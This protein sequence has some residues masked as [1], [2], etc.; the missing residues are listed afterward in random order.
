VANYFGHGIVK[1]T[2]DG[3]VSTF[4]QFLPD[5]PKGLAFD[6]SGVLF[7][8]VGDTIFKYPG[9]VRTT[10]AT[11]FF[12]DPWGLAFDSSSNLFV[13]CRSGAPNIYKFT[14]GGVQTIF[15]T[16]SNSGGPIGIA[17]DASGNLFEGNYA[18][19]NVNIFSRGR[20]K[21]ICKWAPTAFVH[22]L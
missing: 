4:D 18:S 22:C 9:G 16:V 17:F 19:G 3:V 21:H 11:I 2:P 12:E 7:A 13:A 14:P 8:S 6:R 10:F 1:Y 20:S 15:A 5:Y